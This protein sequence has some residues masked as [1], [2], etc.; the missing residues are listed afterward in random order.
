MSFR[1]H[2][3]GFAWSSVITFGRIGLA[4]R[5]DKSTYAGALLGACGGPF[6][7]TAASLL[8][9]ISIVVFIVKPENDGSFALRDC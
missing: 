6:L 9:A 7:E 8:V 3:G 2:V 1:G 5:S 4:G